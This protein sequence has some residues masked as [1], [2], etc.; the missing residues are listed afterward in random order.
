MP[1]SWGPSEEELLGTEQAEFVGS[2][3]DALEDITADELVESL[4]TDQGYSDSD[5]TDDEE[6]AIL[7]LQAQE[8]EEEE[9]AVL[10]EMEDIVY[11]SRPDA[12]QS[13]NVSSIISSSQASTSSPRKRGR[14]SV[15]DAES[16]SRAT[17]KRVAVDVSPMNTP[18]SSS[19]PISSAPTR[20]IDELMAMLRP[21]PGRSTVNDE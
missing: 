1:A 5:F 12:P 8:E 10:D 15:E 21:P 9:A 17:G 13:D 18:S 16:P 11:S 2:W 19:T 14:V 4:D 3:E 20:S 6:G 7:P